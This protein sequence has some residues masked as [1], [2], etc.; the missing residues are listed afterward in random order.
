MSVQLKRRMLAAAVF[1]TASIAMTTA[2]AAA[3]P[4]PAATCQ[5]FAAQPVYQ[6][7][8]ILVGGSWSGCPAGTRITVVLREDVSFWPDRTLRSS[9]GSG[10]SG[11]LPL[12]YPCGNQFDP[13]KVFTETRLG[14]RHVQ[15]PRSVLPCA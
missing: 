4:A 7:V 2:P 10:A 8:S 14:D 5:L 3:A 13:I 1:A 9:T 6:N 11:S 15:S 12:A